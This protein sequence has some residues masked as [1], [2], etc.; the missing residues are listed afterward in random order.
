[1]DKRHEPMVL[2]WGRILAPA[3]FKEDDDFQ[4]QSERQLLLSIS[5]EYF[6]CPNGD[7]R[8]F[9]LSTL[10]RKVKRFRENGID[11]LAPNPRSDRKKIRADREMP[12]KR[13][14]ELKRANPF[15]SSFIIQMMLKKED[16]EEIPRSTLERHFREKNVTAKKLGYEKKMVR[17]RWTRDHTHSLWVGDFYEGAPIIDKN[18]VVRRVWLS[19]FIDVHS[20][21]I[22]SGVY[23]FNCDMKALVY[24]LLIAFERH[25]KP[26]SI[27]VDNAKV[28]RSPIFARACL[29]LGINLIHR[30]PY[31]P[32]GGGIIERF[33]LTLQSQ[34]G[35]E[36][37]QNSKVPLTLERINKL[38]EAWVNQA[39]HQRVHSETK[40]TPNQRYKDGLQYSIVPI[41]IENAEKSFYNEVTRRVHSDFSDISINKHFYKVDCKLRTDRVLARYPLEDLPDTL[42]IYSV[43]G[44]NFLG[45]GILHHRT[46]RH[47][48]EPPPL[49]VEDIDFCELILGLEEKRKKTIQENGLPSLTENKKWDLA[50]FLTKICHLC[51]IEID[52]FDES[53]LETLA[54]IHKRRSELCMKQLRKYWKKCDPQN[55][56]TL[57]IKLA[58]ELL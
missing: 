41:L 43:K 34:L 24:S 7:H 31:D 57:L 50:T 21:F 40:Q 13:A 18:G 30:A 55:L 58:E 56:N 15:R 19:A 35:K 53:E 48:P 44:E 39:Y 29:D 27:Y 33:F 16:H 52:T 1:M 49:P 45:E 4:S 5:E 11:G 51:K 8:K 2:F 28:Y 9:S 26:K 38:F 3:L 36:L 23:A 47:I 14:V 10:K 37:L 6:L 20:R 32:E 54:S 46:E 42:E 12:L 22:V 25:G 17:K